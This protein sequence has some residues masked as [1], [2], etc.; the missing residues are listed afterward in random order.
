MK[1]TTFLFLFLYAGLFDLQAQKV[2]GVYKGFM[3]VDSPKNTINFELTL[4]EKKGKKVILRSI[5]TF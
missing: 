4:K 3:E 1:K 2:V 5:K